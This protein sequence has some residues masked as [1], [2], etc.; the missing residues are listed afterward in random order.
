MLR[1]D[2]GKILHHQVIQAHLRDPPLQPG[3]LLLKSGTLYQDL[4]A[5]HSTIAPK[6]SKPFTSST[7]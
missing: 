6:T 7:A 2:R 5:N 4:G 1:E 3:I